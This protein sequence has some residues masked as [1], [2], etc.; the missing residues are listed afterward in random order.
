MNSLN[1]KPVVIPRQPLFV[2]GITDKNNTFAYVRRDHTRIQVRKNLTHFVRSNL[3]TVH[4]HDVVD[5]SHD[6]SIDDNM[7]DESDITTDYA[8][9]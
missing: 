4:K 6:T 9:D 8:L 2:R 5:I 1:A 3:K 7:S